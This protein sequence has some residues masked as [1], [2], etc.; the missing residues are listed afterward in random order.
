MAEIRLLTPEDAEGYLDHRRRALGDEPL[1][2]AASPEDDVASSVDAVRDLLSRT[3]ESVV[4]GAFSETLV[5]S[6]GIYRDR[7]LKAGHKAH[8]WG[9]YV[10][11]ASRRHG[12]GRALLEAA[13]GHA[14]ALGGVCL[15]HLSVSETAPA[16]KGL[17]TDFGF[18]V[19]G[20]EPDSLRYH[21]ESAAQDHMVLVLD[22]GAPAGS[23]Q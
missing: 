21:G 3:P 22:P 4:F 20:T 9:M 14:R 23:S 15:V 6:I 7:H 12:I 19:W 16:A 11:P 2:F 17:Y 10:E 5:G 13:V 18:R 8:I 1:A